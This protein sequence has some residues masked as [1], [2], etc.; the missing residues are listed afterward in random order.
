MS[1]FGTEMK[2]KVQHMVKTKTKKGIQEAWEELRATLLI[3][4]KKV[5][6]KL[7]LTVRQEVQN[8]LQEVVVRK[9]INRQK[10]KMEIMKNCP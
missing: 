5:L 3:E 7:L 4:V 10:I 8:M 9:E 2:S 1:A 6:E